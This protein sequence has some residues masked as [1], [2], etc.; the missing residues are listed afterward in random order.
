[1]LAKLK[2]QLGRRQQE[3]AEATKPLEWIEKAM[4]LMIDQ[5]R[6][7]LLVA[8][9]K[10]LAERAKVLKDQNDPDKPQIKA[11]MQE[12]EEEQEALA[13]ELDVLLEDILEHA[14][15]LPDEEFFKKLFTTAQDFHDALRDSGAI[16]TMEGAVEDLS[17]F[18]GDPAMV[19]IQKAADIL[20]SFLSKCKGMGGE[21]KNCPPA[22]S[23]NL[24]ECLGNLQSTMQ[25]MLNDAFSSGSGS[26]GAGGQQGRGGNL[27][28]NI[29]GMFQG[30]RTGRGKGSTNEPI[31]ED[32]P[33]GDQF[34][35]ELWDAVGTGQ[36]ATTSAQN[37]I[38]TQ[39]RNR[40][41]QYFQKVLE[42]HA[43]QSREER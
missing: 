2:K 27:F 29:A 10:D 32:A 33:L 23:P 5:Q 3:M 43:K 8:R 34:D 19:K 30:Q 6:F 24:S 25:Q 17:H 12:L 9:Q 11:L 13:I 42:E 37:A 36:H 16:E 39:Y 14:D 31:E 15:A 26:Y 18:R 38:P 35:Y 28:G 41:G 22:F 21:C 20:E 1:M 4:P 7:V 40:V